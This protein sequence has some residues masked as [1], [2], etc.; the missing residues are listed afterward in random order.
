ME[1]IFH[2]NLNMKIETISPLFI[3]CEKESEL[4]KGIDYIQIDEENILIIDHSKLRDVLLKKKLEELFIEKLKKGE[5]R[6]INKF[7]KFLKENRINLEDVISYKIK[8]VANGPIKRFI[9]SAGRPYIPGSSIKGAIRTAFAYYLLL[10]KNK[11]ELVIK[12]IKDI[13]KTKKDPR[14]AFKNLNKEVF[15]EPNYDPMKN[16][17]ISDTNFYEREK[18]V[19]YSLKRLN[20]KNKREIAS[21]SCECIPKGVVLEFSFK[22]NE[23]L[24]LFNSDFEF[25]KDLNKIFD[26]INEFNRNLIEHELAILK[27]FDD[28]KKFYEDLKQSMRDIKNG[29]I[30]RIGFG[31]TFWHQV[32]LI[33]LKDEK[34]LKEY[35]REYLN[36]K[37]WKKRKVMEE[38]PLPISRWFLYDKGKKGGLGW[39]KLYL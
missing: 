33:I 21:L 7:L 31:K 35:E 14:E 29:A 15:G 32:I 4:L 25:I 6:E 12:E 38:D 16:L 22:I 2:L 19:V 9:N 27:D 39:V 30:L 26:I 5:M 24:V 3:G 17:I 34:I 36:K 10:L 13:I 28:I 1:K 23:P 11:K 8:G 20:I 37:V 18:M